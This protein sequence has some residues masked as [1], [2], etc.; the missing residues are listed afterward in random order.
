MAFVYSTVLV[1]YPD[2]TVAKMISR[3]AIEKRF[4]ACVNLFPVESTFRWEGGVAE[5]SEVAA[6]YKIRTTDFTDL[7]TL[8]LRRHPY[9]LPC[10]V[11]YDITDGH[12]LYLDWIRESTARLR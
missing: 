1:T 3:E 7:K 8:I 6:I 10:I 12:S 2:M 4:A 9:Q 11:M 5:E